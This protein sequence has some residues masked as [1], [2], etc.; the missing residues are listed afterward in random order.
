MESP[1]DAFCFALS[2]HR[3]HCRIVL[4]MTRKAAKDSTNRC[5][6]RL[7]GVEGGSER[8]GGDNRLMKMGRRRLLRMIRR[9]EIRPK[10]SV[11]FL[12]AIAPTHL[13][14]VSADAARARA[15][16]F[17]R[18]LPSVRP[19]VRPSARREFLPPLNARQG[20]TNYSA[21]VP[22]PPPPLSVSLSHLQVVGK[23]CYDLRT[24]GVV[25]CVDTRPG[26]GIKTR[27]DWFKFVKD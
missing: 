22:P 25:P 15:V 24:Y 26:T 12:H 1:L 20:K 18:L 7:S 13:F 6:A 27:W 2:S 21:A 8:R 17:E 5:H 23:G 14:W 4:D 16:T 10:E 3:L 19:S 11:L 9:E